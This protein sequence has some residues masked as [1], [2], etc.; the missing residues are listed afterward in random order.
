MPLM[1]GPPQFVVTTQA[2]KSIDL[3]TVLITKCSTL[4]ALELCTVWISKH[5]DEQWKKNPFGSCFKIPILLP[6]TI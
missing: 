4:H 5:F 6:S 1:S 2:F 3:S